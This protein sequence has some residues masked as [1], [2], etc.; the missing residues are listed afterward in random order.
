MCSSGCTLPVFLLVV[1]TTITA[2]RVPDAGLV[3]L[4]YAAGMALILFIV[5]LAAT[6]WG[7][8]LR[9][10][11]FPLLRWVQPMAALL[12]IAA[13]GYIIVYQVRAGLWEEATE[14]T[15]GAP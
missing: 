13:G 14:E 1:G 10:A 6:T 15:K 3:L 8:L 9:S 12:L 5:A 7:D 2:G 4:S 11:I